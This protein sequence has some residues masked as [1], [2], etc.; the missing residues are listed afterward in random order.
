MA[1][2][3]AV[4]TMIYRDDGTPYG[5][6]TRATPASVWVGNTRFVADKQPGTLTPHGVRVDYRRR[7]FV[8]GSQILAEHLA[9]LA[10]KRV[11]EEAAQ[12]IR[13]TNNRISAALVAATG[14]RSGEPDSE[15]LA[16]L[17]ALESALAPILTPTP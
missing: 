13:E 10:R 11:A 9:W 1:D 3:A 8:D 16:R 5:A 4:G 15:Y 17:Q 14:R 6:V 12:Q 7:Y 2:L